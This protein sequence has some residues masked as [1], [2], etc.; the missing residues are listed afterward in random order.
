MIEVIK[1]EGCNLISS[2]I[3]LLLY[4]AVSKKKKKTY[5]WSRVLDLFHTFSADQGEID[6]NEVNGA[7]LTNLQLIQ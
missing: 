5:I 7:L 1:K 4:Q 6:V 2:C 3:N